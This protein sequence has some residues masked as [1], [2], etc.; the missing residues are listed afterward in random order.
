MR[1]KEKR[2]RE[3]EREITNIFLDDIS[4]D[5]RPHYDPIVT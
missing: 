5:L 2:E 3:R 4:V 1:E